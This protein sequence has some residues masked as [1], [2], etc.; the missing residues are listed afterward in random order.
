MSAAQHARQEL[1]SDRKKVATSDLPLDLDSVLVPVL[2]CDV[3]GRGNLPLQSAHVG[4]PP[5]P[6]SH[7][8]D[9]G[10]VALKLRTAVECLVELSGKAREQEVDESISSTSI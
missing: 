3:G 4:Q 9:S 5:L 1:P 8:D 10:L 7:G 2:C 6:S